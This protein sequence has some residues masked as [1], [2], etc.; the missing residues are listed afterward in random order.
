MCNRPCSDALFTRSRRLHKQRVLAARNLSFAHDSRVLLKEASLTVDDAD[1]VALVG[2][3][4]AGKST[5]LQI[6]VGRFKP[7]EG[8]VERGRGQRIGLLAQEPQLDLERT[9]IETA[10]S[11]LGPVADLLDEH[12][13]LCADPAADPERLAAV[14]AQ[15]QDHGG[16]E[17]DHRVEDVLSRL[18]VLARAERVGSLSG[19]QRRRLDLARLLLDNPE[20]MLLDEPTNH[21]DARGIA[22]LAAELRE[23]RGPV[24]FVSHDRA[25]IDEVGT[26]VVEIDLG[27]L[28][29][30]APPGDQGT[31][32][33]VAWLE[34]KLLRDEVAERTQHKKNRLFLR[35]LAWL[36]AGTPARTTKQQARIQRAEDLQNQVEDEA[37]Q[38]RQRK[39]T[40][41]MESAQKKRLG[42]TILEFQ[43]VAIARGG[44]TLF[45]GLNLIVTRGQRWGIVG[46]NGTGKTSLLA[47][48]LTACGE[49]SGDAAVVPAQGRVVLGDNTKVAVFDQHR[50]SL[51]PEATLEDVLSAQNDHVFLDD[52]RIHVSGYLERF[53]FDGSDRYRRVKTLSGGEQN[54]LVFA[55]LFLGNANLL[56][57]DE[58]TNDLDV[59]TLGVLE[60]ALLAHDGCALIVSHDRRFLDRVATGILAF[61]QETPGSPTQVVPVAGDWTHYERT[62]AQRRA[63]TAS[64]SVSSVGTAAA[65]LPAVTA[66]PD[67]QKKKRSY[68]EEQEFQGIEARI[69]QKETR[70]DEVRGILGEGAVFR[71]DAARAKELTEELSGL[72][73]EV[74]RLYLRW[75][76]LGELTPM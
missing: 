73:A 23:H 58:P 10:R 30:Y 48:V 15:I 76:A 3:N 61:E 8:V 74:E 16:F 22:F 13:R 55:K 44:R 9:V 21:L 50:R 34:Q 69:L 41:E 43:D 63:L 65:A 68:K 57:L 46:E 29:P 54:R 56:L 59:M 64:P 67:R 37:Q 12:A 33:T 45:A 72:D 36:R 6:L 49:A 7:D 18:G 39:A 2:R 5:L 47:A 40:V 38:I 60:E 52:T 24:I 42:K 25:F 71:S 53:L 51:D 26:R 14:T 11:A 32:L 31:P 27:Q 1:R 75:Q 62:F 20:V 19:G 66:A 35:E 17:V 28:I 70:R 4:G